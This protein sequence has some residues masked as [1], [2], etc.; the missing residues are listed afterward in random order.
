MV[1]CELSREATRKAVFCKNPAAVVQF[2]HVAGIQVCLCVRAQDQ[3]KI[4][5]AR[6][7]A[8]VQLRALDR[9]IRDG[10]HAAQT[11]R[12]VAPFDRGSDGH[13]QVAQV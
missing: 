6:Q 4:G 12:G 1:R 3:L 2:D 9:A 13:G 8:A 5:S 7:D 11:S 10:D